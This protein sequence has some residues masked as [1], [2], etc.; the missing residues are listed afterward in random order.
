MLY[1]G[2]EGGDQEA[3]AV[4]TWATAL[5]VEQAQVVMYR[6]LQRKTSPYLIGIE[7]K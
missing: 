3:D 1:P 6:Q 7:K 2:H 5:P 4:S